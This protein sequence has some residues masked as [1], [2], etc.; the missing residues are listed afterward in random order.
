MML[1]PRSW[2]WWFLR[3]LHRILPLRR[4]LFIFLFSLR[5]ERLL[6]SR[7]LPSVSVSVSISPSG[8]GRQR[9][10]VGL[11]TG[12][13]APRPLLSFTRFFL[14][15]FCLFF[16]AIF[17]ATFYFISYKSFSFSFPFASFFFFFFTLLY[18]TFLFFFILFFIPSV[19]TN[20]ST[21][22]PYTPL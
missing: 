12:Y 1:L 21:V 5:V 10:K 7:I 14:P 22:P 9:Q 20:Q 19:S 13:P 16:L 15:A 17:L 11:P 3:L 18:I 8:L 2:R 6:E 4:K